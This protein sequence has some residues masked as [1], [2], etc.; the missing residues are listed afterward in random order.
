M[1]FEEKS[2]DHKWLCVETDENGQTEYSI[3]KAYYGSINTNE[4]FLTIDGIQYELYEKGIATVKNYFGNADVDLYESCE[5]IDYITKD[6]KNVISVEKWEGEIEKSQGEYIDSLRVRITNEQ[7]IEK[8]QREKT[9]NKKSK[10][11]VLMICALFFLPV[12]FSLFSTLFSGLFVNKSIG[13]YLEKQSKAS[14][15]KYSYV[16]SVTNNT[17]NKKAKVYKSTLAT[18]DAV[19]KDIIDGVPEGITDT[20]DSDPNTQED[21]IGLHTS[22]EFAYI[23]SENGAIY[24]QISEKEYVNNAGGTT[25]HSRH[26]TH[27]Y[28]TY[29]STRKSTEYSNYS[30]SARQNSINSRLSSGGGTSS[31][32]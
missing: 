30:Y 1:R 18:I 12:I 19:V 28:R 23:Y 16:T 27:Y 22:K 2:G 26:H 24:V 14:S 10:L 15:P 8:M 4:M 7:D 32:K 11:L 17:N 29:S 25:Y 13:K 21:G 5:Y 20:I 31:G 6:K 9:E 3:Y